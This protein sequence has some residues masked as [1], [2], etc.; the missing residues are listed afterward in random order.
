M[1]FPGVMLSQQD[2]VFHVLLQYNQGSFEFMLTPKKYKAQAE[3][4][5]NIFRLG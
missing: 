1:L 2:S 5:V 4:K 3:N